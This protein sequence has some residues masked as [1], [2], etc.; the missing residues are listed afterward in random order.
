MTEPNISLIEILSDRFECAMCHKPTSFE[1]MELNSTFDPV[2]RPC[3]LANVPSEDVEMAVY[4][5]ELRFQEPQ[6]ETSHD[7]RVDR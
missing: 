7:A 5:T 2:C 4:E 1:E 6:E 3:Y